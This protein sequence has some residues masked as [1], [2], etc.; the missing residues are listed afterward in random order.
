ML[1]RIRV[2]AVSGFGQLTLLRPRKGAEIDCYD[3]LVEAICKQASKDFK[4]KSD[5][6][7]FDAM[8][9][10]RSEWFRFLTDDLLD[11]EEII[12]KLL[13]G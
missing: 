8:D 11:G 9:F 10:F 2:P 13:D 3:L 7:R 12:N 4:G 5:H 6:W 1:T